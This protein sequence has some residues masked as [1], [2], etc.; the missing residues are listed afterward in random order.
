M[1]TRE[2]A[3]VVLKAMGIYWLVAAMLHILRGV[4]MPFSEMGSLPSNI[5]KIEIINWIVVGVIYAVMSYLLLLRTASVLK[6]IKLDEDKEAIM[7]PGS[8]IDFKD[9]SFALLGMY[10]LVTSISAIAPQLIKLWSLR[11]PP[12]TAR[13]FQEAYLEKSW[14]S[15]L[16]NAIQFLFGAVLVIG[17]SRLRKLWQRFR[18]LGTSNEEESETK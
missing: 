5:V 16:E 2:L 13:M 12:P 11:Q 3:N 15:L 9:L 6:L 4:L 10:F 17:R 14:A 8:T 7:I 18:P 1:K